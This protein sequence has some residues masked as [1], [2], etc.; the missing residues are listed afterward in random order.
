YSANATERCCPPVH[1]IAMTTCDFPSFLYSGIIK[2]NKSN[3][4][5]LNCFVSIHLKTYSLT[6]SSSPV[7]GR[8]DVM[9]KGLGKN[10]TSNTKSASIGIPY[11]NPNETKYTENTAYSS[12][13]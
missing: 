13:A 3:S 9:Y 10:R 11:L 12:S 1:P 6:S 8:I 7:K 2:K 5:S 4:F